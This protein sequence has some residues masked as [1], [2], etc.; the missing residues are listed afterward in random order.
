[1]VI[2]KFR[3]VLEV[4]NEYMTHASYLV[5]E[6]EILEKKQTRINVATEF[7]HKI[8]CNVP[9]FFVAEQSF[10]DLHIDFDV[11]KNDKN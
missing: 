3:S 10:P 2:K 11:E 6:L 7:E 1:M 9:H 5:G 8:M 4:V